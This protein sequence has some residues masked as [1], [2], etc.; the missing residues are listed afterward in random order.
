MCIECTSVEND[1]DFQ[2]DFEPFEIVA[3]PNR[4]KMGLHI[5]KKAAK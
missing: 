2:G 5:G 3:N 4:R 1:S